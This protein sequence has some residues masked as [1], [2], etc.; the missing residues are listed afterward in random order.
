M[1]PVQKKAAPF[2]RA[3]ADPGGPARPTSAAISAAAGVN[4]YSAQTASPAPTSVCEALP[5]PEWGLAR[6]G[7]PTTAPGSS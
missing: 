2:Y 7:I 4:P 5:R 3:D 6:C 1:A